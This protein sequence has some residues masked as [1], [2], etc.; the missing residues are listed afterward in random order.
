MI[1][2]ISKFQNT[3]T[4]NTFTIQ[5]QSTQIAFSGNFAKLGKNLVEDGNSKFG[6]KIRRFAEETTESIVRA[7]K[8][9]VGD[10]ELPFTEKPLTANG[11]I[12]H[13]GTDGIST[14]KIKVPDIEIKHP[15]VD[16]QNIYKLDGDATAP[17][18]QLTEDAET[19]PIIKLANK[20]EQKIENVFDKPVE[21]EKV[22]S[23]KVIGPDDMPI[24]DG[25]GKFIQETE[26]VVSNPHKVDNIDVHPDLEPEPE[27]FNIDDYIDP[28]KY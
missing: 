4:N 1:T 19:N 10:N 25:N 13:I 12:I 18:K 27:S 15:G 7:L 16:G 3:K 23:S 28:F 6:G 9:L 2:A 5:K 8:K 17:I 20:I 22:D 24:T 14:I 21:S 11:E 26:N